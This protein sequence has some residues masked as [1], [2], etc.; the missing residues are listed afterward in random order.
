MVLFKQ[1]I[2]LKKYDLP[3]KDLWEIVRDNEDIGDTK[4]TRDAR[5]IFAPRDMGE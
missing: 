4:D 2:S 3:A 1:N 5:D